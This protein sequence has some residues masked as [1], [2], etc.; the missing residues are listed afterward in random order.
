MW[1]RNVCVKKKEKCQMLLK[2]VEA[3]CEIEMRKYVKVKQ[4]AK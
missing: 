2:H 3:K 4:N 1:K